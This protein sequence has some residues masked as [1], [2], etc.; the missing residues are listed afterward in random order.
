MLDARLF[1]LVLAAAV[2]AVSAAWAQETY[3]VENWPA[4]LDKIPCGAWEK[5]SDGTWTLAHGSIKVGASVLNHVGFKGDTAARLIERTCG[6][7]K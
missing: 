2:A 7:G 4:D 6:K 3:V 5:T 1:P